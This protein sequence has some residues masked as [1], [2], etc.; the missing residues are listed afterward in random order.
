MVGSEMSGHD[1][2]LAG[3]RHPADAPVTRAEYD[4]FVS[5]FQHEL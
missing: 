1:N 2:D 4:A 5:D 3:S